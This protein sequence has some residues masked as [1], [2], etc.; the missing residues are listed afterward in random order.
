MQRG[1]LTSGAR[2]RHAR[3]AQIVRA[4]AEH[5][6][7]GAPFLVLR[8][9]GRA[10][11]DEAHIVPV[12]V[13]H[14]GVLPAKLERGVCRQESVRRLVATIQRQRTRTLKREGCDVGDRVVHGD[15]ERHLGA[16]AEHV[17]GVYADSHLPP[18]T[19]PLCY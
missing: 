14:L 13:G 16:E 9:H 3:H 12:H 17:L 19:R 10:V 1:R 8:A 15:D 7:I 6:D 11:R 2:V 18:H 4:G 5:P